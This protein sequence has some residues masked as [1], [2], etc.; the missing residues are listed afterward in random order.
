MKVES[1]RELLDEMRTELYDL[2]AA[3]EKSRDDL[4][5]KENELYLLKAELEDLRI[6]CDDFREEVDEL[7]G[8]L[9]IKRKELDEYSQEE[10][11]VQELCD[12]IYTLLLE[13]KNES[14]FSE[15]SF[16][17]IVYAMRELAQIYYY[18][19]RETD[20]LGF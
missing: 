15:K 1:E 11:N 20:N 17:N 19:S 10:T 18:D 3:Y 2:R 16:N 8:D 6:E 14:S 7:Y 4:H 13:V 12:Q 9:A 5:D